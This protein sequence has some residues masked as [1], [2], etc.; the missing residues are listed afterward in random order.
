M[1]AAHIRA[2]HHYPT[3]AFLL[4]AITHLHALPVVGP[5][6]RDLYHG[7]GFIAVELKRGHGDIHILATQTGL[8]KMVQNALMD[9]FSILIS[10]ATGKG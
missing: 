10:A 5:F 8:G 9:R 4:Q 3:A 7:I 1:A 2:A 6:G